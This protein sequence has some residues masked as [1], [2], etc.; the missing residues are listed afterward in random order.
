[1][2]FRFLALVMAAA[3]AQGAA[4]ATLTVNGDGILTGARGVTINGSLYDVTFFDGSCVDAFGECDSEDDYSVR[5]ADAVPFAQALLD[6]VFVG[7]F[8]TNPER[9]LGC[10][11]VSG[12]SSCFVIMAGRP[13]LDTGRMASVYALNLSGG[14]AD[15]VDFGIFPALLDLAS[16]THAAFAPST[17][18]P[19][20]A[21]AWGLLTGLGGL[22]V[23]GRRAARR[24]AG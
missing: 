24:R 9:T 6:Q 11:G 16:F 13:T 2:A 10:S 21:A 7:V 8:D 15:S 3:L 22:L 12:A 14:N 4:A 23:M 18:I 19:L 5:F 17:V 20:P 1:M